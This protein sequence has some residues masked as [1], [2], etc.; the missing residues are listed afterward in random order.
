[1]AAD[2]TLLNPGSG[3]ETIR[4]LGDAGGLN[5]PVGVSAYATTIS[6]GAN[7]LQIVDITHGM[8]VQPQTG[9]TWAVTGAFWQAT[10]PVSIAATVA[11]SAASLPLPAGAATAANQATG[12][13]SLASIDGKLPALVGGAVPVSLPGG[14]ATSAG[15]ASIITALG[16]IG[17][18]VAVSNFPGTQAVSAASLPLPTGASTEA[19]LSTLN[20][21]VTAVNTGAVVLAAGAAKVGVFTTDQ[22][23]HGTTDLVAADITKVAGATVA[24]GH[25]TASGA[26]RVELPTD[27]TGVVG[28]SQALDATNDAIRT[29]AVVGH[30]RDASGTDLTVLR[31]RVT[32]SGT[33]A[34]QLVAAVTS[35]QILVL[36]YSVQ[37]QASGTPVFNFQDNAGSP[38]V[39]SRTWQL[40]QSGAVGPNGLAFAASPQG[41]GVGPTTAGQALMVKLSAAVSTVVEATYVVY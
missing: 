5:W 2:N 10:Q 1:M 21:K 41:C 7:V 3:G 38:V 6:A 26:I 31:A 14:L 25:G 24:T 39:L 13:T 37:V 15:Q 33:T 8:P 28:F 22:T 9:S 11:V 35:K 12:N 19:T 32:V 4:S 34:T 36:G 40:D 29:V 27:G 30:L 17:G 18:T 20:A 16:S 23:T